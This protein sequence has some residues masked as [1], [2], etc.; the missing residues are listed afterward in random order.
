MVDIVPG[1]ELSPADRAALAKENEEASKEAIRLA[2]EQ[3][4]RDAMNGG[5]NVL[6]NV[7][8]SIKGKLERDEFMVVV[9][10]ETGQHVPARP[11]KEDE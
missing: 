4:E 1:K 10:D 7:A 2:K 3:A 8:D 9:D 6:A 5:G 11:Q